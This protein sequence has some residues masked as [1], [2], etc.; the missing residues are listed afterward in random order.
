MMLSRRGCKGLCCAALKRKSYI[1][2]PAAQ[3][4]GVRLRHVP[5]LLRELPPSSIRGLTTAAPRLLPPRD[6]F[7]IFNGSP[8]DRA[9][10]CCG[11][12]FSPVAHIPFVD[13]LPS[14]WDFGR[15]DV[16]RSSFVMWDKGGNDLLFSL[17]RDG[18]HPAL[19]N[20]AL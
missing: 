16:N 1:S 10:P 17:W 6:F 19:R 13:E 15:R 9:N 12:Q 7:R 5:A 4:P 14:A 11:L 3:A 18:A 8:G 20:A 2:G